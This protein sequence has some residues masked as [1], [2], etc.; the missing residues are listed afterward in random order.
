[1]TRRFDR[2]GAVRAVHSAL[3]LSTAA[4]FSAGIARAD[5]GELGPPP[6]DQEIKQTLIDMYTAGKP[7]GSIVDVR[8]EGPIIV[9]K[10]MM[11]SNPPPQPWCV[12]CG[13]PDQGASLM[14]PVMAMPV[15]TVHQDLVSSAL[16]V[17]NIVDNTS[18]LNGSAC[19]AEPRA[20]ICTAYY[21]YR[22]GEGNWRI[23]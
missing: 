7:L 17:A 16:G 18:T 4:L 15:V 3:L 10:P 11:H 6:V 21:F 13:Y 1:M 23:T 22:D 19:P 9:G 12:R 14:Y 8:F 5:V 2:L 20:K